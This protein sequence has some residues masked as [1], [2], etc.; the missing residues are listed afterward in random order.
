MNLKLLSKIPVPNKDK[1]KKKL[2]S[3]DILRERYEWKV[4]F[5]FDLIGR[6]FYSQI[7]NAKPKVQILDGIYYKEK[8][9]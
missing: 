8:V 5:M 2:I 9:F 6:Q 1:K 3:F 4:M 7:L